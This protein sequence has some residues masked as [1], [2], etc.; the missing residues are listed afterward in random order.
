LARV[1]QAVEAKILAWANAVGPSIQSL[2]AQGILDALTA[3]LR[4]FVGGA[5]RSD[6]ITLMVLMRTQ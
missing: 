3:E 4:A 2:S 6:D 1:I 5:P